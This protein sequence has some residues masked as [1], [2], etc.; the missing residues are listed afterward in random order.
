MTEQ[1]S[2]L[3]CDDHELV[4]E[5]LAHV[6]R[7]E[8]DFR[9][10]TAKDKLTCLE[11]AVAER[12]DVILLDLNM[13]G[14]DQF[15]GVEEVV[16]AA[17]ESKIV[18]LSGATGTDLAQR[19]LEH[20]ATGYVPKTMPLKALPS[21]LRLIAA[22][23]VYVPAALRQGAASTGNGKLTQREMAVARFLHEGRS[24]KEIGRNL[25]I[26]E[27]TAKMVVRS[28]CLKLGA[29]N[30]TQAAITAQREGLV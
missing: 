11:Q 14:M 4:R 16:S 21:A 2:I 5:S 27:V 10:N 17:P 19:S 9:V 1:L 15:E 6:L 3:L 25:G 30:R 7:E 18:V 29:K 28:I 20:G 24:N 23:E 12:Y 8:G 26:S 22:G 13:P